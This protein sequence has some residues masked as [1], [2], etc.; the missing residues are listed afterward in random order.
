MKMCDVVPHLLQIIEAARSTERQYLATLSCMKAGQ[1]TLQFIYFWQEHARMVSELEEKVR[2]LGGAVP[3]VV[4]S[5]WSGLHFKS[6]S[7][8]AEFSEA[9]W[10][11][12]Q[13]DDELR[14][15]YEFALKN[16]LPVD[17]RTLLKVHVLKLS[18]IQARIGN[19]ASIHHAGR[20]RMDLHPRDP[21]NRILS[22][23]VLQ[24]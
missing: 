23:V 6:D 11:C 13:A 16:A 10:A 18:T 12:T 3:D 17:V 8:D 7:E 5:A 2:W 21:Q 20:V 22:E 4:G 19:L 1:P 15:R 14:S 9:L 24:A